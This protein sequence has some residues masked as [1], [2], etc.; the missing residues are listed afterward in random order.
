MFRQSVSFNFI[1]EITQ[2]IS[3]IPLLLS[4]LLRV[5]QRWFLR[6]CE[7]TRRPSMSSRTV[8]I[9]MGLGV[10]SPGSGSRLSVY[11]HLPSTIATRG[12]P[13]LLDGKRNVAPFQWGPEQNT[14][15]QWD[16]SEGNISS[17]PGTI[18]QPSETFLNIFFLTITIRYVFSWVP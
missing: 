4:Q 18:C 8:P 13:V 16:R 17:F 10:C 14:S 15:I 11:S 3:Q 5:C 7:H 12:C 1:I 6:S 9:C 2:F